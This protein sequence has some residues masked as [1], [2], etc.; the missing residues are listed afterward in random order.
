MTL[1]NTFGW[2]GHRGWLTI[3][4]DS[5]AIVT[6]LFSLTDFNREGSCVHVRTDITV[7]VYGLITNVSAWLEA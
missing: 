3:A 2:A 6:F 4:Q 1:A 7:T 5:Y